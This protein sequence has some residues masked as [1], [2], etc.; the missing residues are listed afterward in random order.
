MAGKPPV[1]PMWDSL[2]TPLGT[3]CQTRWQLVMSS[4]GRS[5]MVPF[6]HVT[7]VDGPYMDDVPLEGPKTKTVKKWS[8]NCFGPSQLTCPKTGQEQTK[9]RDAR[10]LVKRRPAN[11]QGK[12]PKMMK[13]NQKPLKKT[14]K[15]YSCQVRFYRPVGCNPTPEDGT[16]GDIRGPPGVIRALGSTSRKSGKW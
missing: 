1:N 9:N 15:N 16:F 14:I 4:I 11:R 12:Q 5:Q 6:V 13:N 3:P 7:F 8:G 10:I 2:S